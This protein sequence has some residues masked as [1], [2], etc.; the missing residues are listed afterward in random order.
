VNTLRLVTVAACGAVV[1]LGCQAA[2]TDL[3]APVPAPAS[4]EA[5]PDE[6]DDAAARVS[7]G[8]GRSEPMGE[9][10]SSIDGFMR[11][12]RSEGLTAEDALTPGGLELL[13]EDVVSAYLSVSERRALLDPASPDFKRSVAVF[14]AMEAQYAA[15]LADLK[16]GLFVLVNEEFAKRQYD[17]Q[18]RYPQY[19]MVLMSP[20]PSLR[21]RCL[22]AFCLEMELRHPALMEARRQESVAVRGHAGGVPHNEMRK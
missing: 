11:V 12:L 4:V 22:V 17:P 2:C 20:K 21:G 7:G 18:R 19:L 9:S 6:N 15:Q 14:N 3:G 5:A 10:R 8:L 16:D 13:E 1:T